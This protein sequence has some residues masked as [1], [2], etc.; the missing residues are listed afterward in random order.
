VRSLTQG[1][2]TSSAGDALGQDGPGNNLAVVGFFGASRG[3]YLKRG[4]DDRYSFGRA[5]GSAMADRHD[6]F[7]WLFSSVYGRPQLRAVTDTATE[8]ERTFVRLG[9]SV[10]QLRGGLGQE[11]CTGITRPTPRKR[12]TDLSKGLK[13][14]S[15]I[16]EHQNNGQ[17]G[18]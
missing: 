12:S 11:R 15:S 16:S 2:M 1:L 10:V 3:A 9:S 6:G 7:R 13:A 5:S 8:R 14:V 18:D 4:Y 17:R